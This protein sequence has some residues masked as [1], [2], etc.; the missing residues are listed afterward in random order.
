MLRI[1]KLS[2][3]E[4]YITLR[5]EGRI[6]SECVAVLE[7]HC[8]EL[9]H[10]GHRVRLDAAEVDFVDRAGVALLKELLARG[11]EIEKGSL[12]VESLL[13]DGKDGG[14]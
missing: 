10:G 3:P 14:R 6:A 13:M 5:I 9:L 4:P 12:T 2:G 1:T 11:V 8:T 7:C